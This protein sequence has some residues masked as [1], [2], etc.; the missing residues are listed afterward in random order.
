MSLR[1]RLLITSVVLVAAGLLVANVATYRLLSNFLLHRTDDQL[2]AAQAPVLDALQFGGEAP[3]H[4]TPTF[5]VPPGTYAEVRN[6]SGAP[7]V[8]KF[9]GYEIK[10]DQRPV[11]P[12]ALPGS[13]ASTEVGPTFFTTT[14]GRG[15]APTYRAVAAALSPGP[16]T[17]IVAIP[18]TEVSATLERLR[19]APGRWV[20]AV[21]R[22]AGPSS[23]GRDRGDRRRHRGRRPLAPGRAGD[24]ADRGRST[25]PRPERDARP[26]RGGVRG[27]PGLR[28]SPAALRRRR[29]SRAPHT[30]HVD[31]WVRRAVPPRR[32]LE[33]RGSGQVHATHRGRGGAHGRL[34]GRPA[35]VGPARPGTTA[36]SRAGRSRSHRRG[37]R[38]QRSRSGARPSHRPRA[39]RPRLGVGR[40]GAVA[41]GR[42]QPV[43]QR[44]GPHPGELASSGDSGTRRRWRRAPERGGRRSWS[45]GAGCHPRLRAVLPR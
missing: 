41:P 12:K 40:R 21:A 23:A 44:A 45:P 7:L 38:R 6:G 3:A 35:P 27:A 32:R 37:G 22:E 13:V 14:T 29:L 26:D 15:G 43:G 25:G 2:V 1:A 20:R 10:T 30:A 33:A 18:L 16:G 34:G 28:E 17:L 5:L 9:F 42:G 19:A 24:G 8:W 39:P 31:P 11:C 4:Q 36:G